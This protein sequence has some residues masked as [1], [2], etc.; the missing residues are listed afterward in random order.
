[1]NDGPSDAVTPPPDE[2]EEV[3]DLDDEEFA[4]LRGLIVEGQNEVK[5]LRE[6]AKDY[7]SLAN[8]AEQ[9]ANELIGDLRAKRLLLRQA[10]MAL[11]LR[12]L[13]EEVHV[14]NVAL[15]RLMRGDGPA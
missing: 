5:T 11:R 10:E 15:G 1:M 4:E 8:A 7:H 9:R 2:P 12:E 3:P 14:V 13:E 6:R